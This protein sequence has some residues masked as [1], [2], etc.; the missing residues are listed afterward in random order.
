M[1]FDAA[2]R[3]AVAGATD[4]E[5][6]ADLADHA[7][8]EFQEEKALPLI[9]RAI[10]KHPSARLWQWK[11]LLERSLDAHERALASFEAAAKLDSADATIAHGHARVALEAGIP[12]EQLYERARALAP[13]DGSVLIGLAA[14][15]LAAGHGEQAEAELDAA[16]LASP[17]W[18]QG[19]HQLAQLRS[20]M[21]RSQLA[22][23]SL[24]RALAL[25]PD[26]S[27]LW[28]ALFELKVKSEDFVGLA[29]AGAAARRTRAD[30][31]L[32]RMYEAIAAAELGQTER[33]DAIFAAMDGGGGAQ[34]P[35]WLIRHFLR[36]G[37]VEEALPIIDRELKGPRAASIWPYAAIAWR[38]N[39]DERWDW[40]EGGGE[41]VSVIDLSKK[42]PPL[43]RL[44][45]LLRSIHK[46]RG[47][48]LDQSLRGGT[49]TDGPLFS[50]VEPEIRAL[51][52]AVVDAVEAYVAQL[53][54]ARPEHPLL[55][56]RRDRGVRFAGSWSVRLKEEGFHVP[57]V[58]P[59]GWISSAL[60][61]ALPPEA[62]N[63]ETKAGWLQI[64]EPRPEL[65]VGLQPNAYV[66]PEPG[67]LVLFPSWMW[68]GTIP[69]PAGE[70]LSV[71]FDVAHPR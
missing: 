52:A 60:Y 10:D 30:A 24:D 7:L 22:S 47:E 65:R 1:S 3:A 67:Q 59:R 58:H 42:L 61:I 16:L 9:V 13:A 50:R 33:A 39:G 38:L 18:I 46:A 15:R 62:D 6:L 21:S 68:H 70:R 53:P 40:L 57:H 19:H 37:R 43:E 34:L 4:A 41:L 25:Q 48:Y 36:T 8:R 49:Q 11:A 28:Q 5:A 54:A 2:M 55:R 29:E 20:M 63:T 66:K 26:Q 12:A 71:A 45:D 69:F 27:A 44:A 64:G 17:L 23:A 35:I 31:S 56:E 32:L 51:R 14:A